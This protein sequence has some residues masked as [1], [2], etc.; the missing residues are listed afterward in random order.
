MPLLT[1]I[2]S[3]ALLKIQDFTPQ[4]VSNTVWSLATVM[5]FDKRVLNAMAVRA[6]GHLDEWKA[7]ELSNTAWA[8]ATVHFEHEPL[9]NAISSMALDRLGEFSPRHSAN[10]AWS[11][12]TLESQQRPLLTM[13]GAAALL[14]LP[15]LSPLSLASTAW[16][17]V[18]LRVIDLP[19]LHAMASHLFRSKVDEGVAT[20]AIWTLSQLD[21]VTAAFQLVDSAAWKIP[22]LSLS[23]LL[24]RCEQEGPSSKELRVLSFLARD[25]FKPL[26][27]EVVASRLRVAREA[28][29]EVE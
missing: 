29:P 11:L 16:A 1:A 28:Q 24:S 7:Q 15:R 3:V 18:T 20:M 6:L 27:E 19:L 17:C 21:D 10:L 2:S 22:P 23:P 5:V 26:T 4:G 13:V 14:G 9:I 8:F 12:A 25:E